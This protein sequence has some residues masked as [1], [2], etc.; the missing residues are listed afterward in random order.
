MTYENVNFW[1]FYL[2]MAP[3]EFGKIWH[4][5]HISRMSSMELFA[6]RRCAANTLLFYNSIFFSP[7]QTISIHWTLEVFKSLKFLW[8]TCCKGSMTLATPYLLTFDFI[9]NFVFREQKNENRHK[10]FHF[11]LG[12]DRPDKYS[13]QQHF[14]LYIYEEQVRFFLDAIKND[15]NILLRVQLSLIIW[16]LVFVINL[17]IWKYAKKSD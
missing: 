14:Q 10:L 1:T 2:K 12:T 17:L 15:I 5:Y 13:L 3:N 9:L 4:L 6:L 16:L 7:I 11:Q 8:T